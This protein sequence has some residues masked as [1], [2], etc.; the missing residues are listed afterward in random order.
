[1]G[2]LIK[3]AII[4]FAITLVAG[5]GLGFVYNVTS[6]ARQEQIERTKQGAYKDV[7]PGFD[8]PDD[9]FNID[10]DE[11]IKYI[12]DKIN[13]TEKS[14]GIKPMK[15]FNAEIEDVV[16]ALDKDGNKIGYIVT[17]IDKEAYG[18]SLKLAVGVTTDKIVKG[19]SFLSLNETPGLG[20]NADTDGFK[21]QFNIDKQIDY[22]EYTKTGKTEDN[23]IDVISSATITTNAVT[24]SVNAAIYCV[25]FI[26][27]GGK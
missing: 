15:E 26:Q 27:G 3:D 8:K 20:M 7:M 9:T 13:N 25:D 14:N 10:V 12:S 17:V 1:M 21:N 16:L 22:F 18:G 4:L 5:L 11:A 23:Q 2:R 24:H 6:D 19:I